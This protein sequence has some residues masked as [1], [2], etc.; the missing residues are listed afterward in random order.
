MTIITQAVWHGGGTSA[1]PR[2]ARIGLA[3]GIYGWHTAET[4][5]AVKDCVAE[6]F[7]VSVPHSTFQIETEDIAEHE[8]TIAKHD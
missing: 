7:E 6:H 8:P 4:L 3:L 1:P 5:R 2:R